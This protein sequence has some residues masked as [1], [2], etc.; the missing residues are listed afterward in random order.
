MVTKVF[1]PT[2]LRTHALLLCKKEPMNLCEECV[3]LVSMLFF[4]KLGIKTRLQDFFILFTLRN[5]EYFQVVISLITF[6][7][8]C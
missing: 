3:S 7:F 1:L 4:F 2:C 5:C 8:P 6:V